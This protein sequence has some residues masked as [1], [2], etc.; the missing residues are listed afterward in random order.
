MEKISKT[1][2]AA[3][4]IIGLIV[5]GMVLIAEWNYEQAAEA[6]AQVDSDGEILAVMQ[7]Y[8]FELDSTFEITPMHKISA[9]VNLLSDERK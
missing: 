2:K 5:T 8:G 9:V 3:F 6:A 1:M 7:D 4:K